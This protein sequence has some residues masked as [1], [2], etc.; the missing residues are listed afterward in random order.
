MKVFSYLLEHGVEREISKDE[1]LY[2]VWEINNMSASTQR[3]WQS[4]KDLRT[5]LDMIGVPKD[6]IISIKGRG[7]KINHKSVSK[8]LI[9][10]LLATSP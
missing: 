2:Q 5:C 8:L 6:F 3:L 9:K 10:N 1:L 4:L 7:Y